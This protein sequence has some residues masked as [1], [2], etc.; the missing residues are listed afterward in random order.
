MACKYIMSQHY[1]PI[2]CRLN[3]EHSGFLRAVASSS[4]STLL[5]VSVI[6]TDN[7]IQF[8][9]TTKDFTAKETEVNKTDK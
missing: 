6:K 3:A 9:F 7:E 5:N 8:L 1:Q 2:H 4:S